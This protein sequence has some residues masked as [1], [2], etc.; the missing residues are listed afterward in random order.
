VTRDREQPCVISQGQ[1]CLEPMS[2]SWGLSRGSHVYLLPL[3]CLAGR[4]WLSGTAK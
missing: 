4:D 3:S 2:Q 1:T